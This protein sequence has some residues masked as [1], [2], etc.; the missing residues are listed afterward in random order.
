[1]PE[2]SGSEPPEI[3]DEAVAAVLAVTPIDP[4]DRCVIGGYQADGTPVWTVPGDVAR[5][6]L[7]A[8]Y[9]LLRQRWE[10]EYDKQNAQI[11]VIVAEAIARA[12]EAAPWADEGP[13]AANAAGIARQCGA[14]LAGP[15]GSE[16]PRAT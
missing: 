16:V 3:S 12:I 7:V 2:L 6:Q 15:N 1:M 5:R 10:D 8:A 9:P 14:R 13:Y 4:D 11:S